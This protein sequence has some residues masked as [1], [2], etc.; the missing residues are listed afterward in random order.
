[1]GATEHAERSLFGSGSFSRQLI[2]IADSFLQA[3]QWPKTLRRIMDEIL[4]LERPG[5][6]QMPAA[7]PKAAA[8][9]QP[10]RTRGACSQPSYHTELSAE[11]LD[12]MQRQIDAAKP[13]NFKLTPI[14][15]A[16]W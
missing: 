14:S 16:G 2:L 4:L 3:Y 6:N 1:M 13:A 7:M 12:G 5:G 11:Y 15:D 10:A 9:A 8:A